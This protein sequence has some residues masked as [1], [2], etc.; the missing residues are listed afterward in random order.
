MR[1]GRIWAAKISCGNREHSY[2]LVCRNWR[3]IA[4]KRRETGG[5]KCGKFN[6]EL[7]PVTLQ[8]DP[9]IEFKDTDRPFLSRQNRALAAEAD[10]RFERAVDA[11]GGA[12]IG[13]G[14]FEV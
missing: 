12:G 6:H 2:R 8:Q 13:E 11:C 7:I 14:M 3:R 9:P 10:Y 4:R 5:R 1:E